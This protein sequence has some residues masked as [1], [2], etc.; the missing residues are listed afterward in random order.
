[1]LTYS[2][3]VDAGWQEE[4]LRLHWQFSISISRG[5][6]DRNA[7]NENAKAAK[8]TERALGS[9]TLVAPAEPLRMAPGNS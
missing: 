5:T 9:L 3:N 8:A 2:C 1:M 6:V 7:E 4:K